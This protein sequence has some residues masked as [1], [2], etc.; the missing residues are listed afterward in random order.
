[1]FHIKNKDLLIKNFSTRLEM[2]ELIRP[3]KSW[4]LCGK[5]LRTIFKKFKKNSKRISIFLANA[6]LGFVELAELLSHEAIDLNKDF[7][8]DKFLICYAFSK[9]LSLNNNG[10]IYKKIKF[11]EKFLECEKCFVLIPA[12][13]FVI[14]P[15][16]LEEF[17]LSHLKTNPSQYSSTIDSIIIVRF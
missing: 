9:T 1:M 4:N 10:K 6:N 3:N 15:Y 17:W 11:P 13:M 5:I 16:S 14:V 12:N 2:F 7:E 8:L